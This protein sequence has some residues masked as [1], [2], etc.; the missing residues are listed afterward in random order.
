MKKYI[1]GLFYSLI[2][3]VATCAILITTPSTVLAAPLHEATPENPCVISAIG[4]SITYSMTYA[5]V[6]DMLPEITV[7]NYGISATQVAGDAEHSFV[8]RTAKEKFKSDIILILGGTN[9]YMGDGAMCNPLGTPDSDDITTFFGAYNTMI[10]NIKKNNPKAQIVLI[11]PLK[12]VG[13]DNKNAYGFALRHY[14]LATQMIA[15]SNDVACIDLF[16]NDRCDFTDYTKS[17]LLIDG[18][19]PTI[20][21]HTIIATAIYQSLIELGY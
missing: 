5:A 12:R 13:F 19:H 11:T 18:L 10:K 20:K 7:N 21:G 2:I 3:V 16:N 4:D 6:L 1:L 14:A 15:Q 17:N 9:D 8:N